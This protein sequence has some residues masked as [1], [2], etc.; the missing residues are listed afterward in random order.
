MLNLE[1]PFLSD[2]PGEDGRL[3]PPAAGTLRRRSRRVNGV[4]KVLTWLMTFL[5]PIEAGHSAQIA[6]PG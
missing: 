3:R 6:Q 5:A 4:Q 2:G 1:R